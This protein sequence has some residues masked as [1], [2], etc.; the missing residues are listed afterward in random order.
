MSALGGPPRIQIPRWIQLVGLPLLL[1]LAW[2]FPTAASHAVFLF[3]V[4]ALIALLL[5]PLVRALERV[6]LRARPLGRDRVLAFA[7]A[8][9]LVIVAIATAV[10]GADE[11]RREPVQRL[12]HNRSPPDG[13]TAADRDVDRLQHW[14]N[15]HHLKGV[16]VAQARPPD[17]ASDPQ[18][19]VGKYT[20][21]IVTFVE[22]AAI[23]IGKGAV[24][25][26]CCS[27]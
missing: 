9:V 22:G 6:R 10:V 25:R 20:K 3:L 16:N 8:L 13:Q 14:L 15:T 21:R 19:D 5:D 1:I 18:R 7:A 17:R 11:D 27:S 26:S 12:F 2:V 23:S 4:A 24:L